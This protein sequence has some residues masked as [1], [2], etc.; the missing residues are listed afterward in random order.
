MK[1]CR[2]KTF[3]YNVL[4]FSSTGPQLFLIFRLIV[5]KYYDAFLYSFGGICFYLLSLNK[6]NE[7]ITNH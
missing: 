1:A 4:L 5:S 6:H 2:Y 7:L 3:P